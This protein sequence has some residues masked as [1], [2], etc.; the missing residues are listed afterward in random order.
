MQRP[1]RIAYATRSIALIHNAVASGSG[2]SVMEASI[3]PEGFEKLDGTA[4]FPDLEDVAITLHRSPAAETPAVA[5][6]AAHLSRELK[7][8]RPDGLAGQGMKAA[9]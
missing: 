6:A 1:W 9:S 2:V 7:G 3:I 5:L 4:G 8:S